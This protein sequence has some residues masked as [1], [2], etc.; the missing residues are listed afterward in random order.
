MQIISRSKVHE[1]KTRASFGE[2]KPGQFSTGYLGNPNPS[3]SSLELLLPF[4]A[5]ARMLSGRRRVRII[6]WRQLRLHLSGTTSPTAADDDDDESL[7][8]ATTRMV[9][10]RRRRRVPLCP[11][12]PLRRLLLCPVGRRVYAVCKVVPKLPSLYLLCLGLQS[13]FET[14]NIRVGLLEKKGDKNTH[15]NAARN[16]HHHHHPTRHQHRP[17]LERVVETTTFRRLC[18]KRRRRR[19]ARGGRFWCSWRT[20]RR[21][22]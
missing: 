1:V 21:E 14:L 16:N 9:L 22:R 8:D 19:L 13:V 20:R 11:P 2:R 17:T 15:K 12:P 4:F 7:T 5:I 10:S 18:Q 6:A 3:G